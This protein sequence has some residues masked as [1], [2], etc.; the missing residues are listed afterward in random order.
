MQTFH[1]LEVFLNGTIKPL[2]SVLNTH[3]HICTQSI[4]SPVGSQAA[5]MIF[6]GKLVL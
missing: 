3:T 4:F 1:V 6:D 5:L 2:V